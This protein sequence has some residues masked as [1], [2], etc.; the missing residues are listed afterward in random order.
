VVARL[1]ATPAQG[2]WEVQTC[3]LAC[4][5]QQG[6]LVELVDNRD[7]TAEL[8]LTLIDFGT[9]HQPLGA[10][11]EDSRFLALQEIHSGAQGGGTTKEGD[12]EDRNVILPVLVPD[13]VR[14]ALASLDGLPI[15][16]ALFE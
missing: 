10:I 8:W 2:Y 1:G 6:R 11:A 4:W 12:V 3:S 5:P 14:P 9:D 13:A 16:S 15:E 7:G